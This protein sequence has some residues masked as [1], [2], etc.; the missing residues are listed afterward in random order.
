MGV[1]WN[2]WV[3]SLGMAPKWMNRWPNWP[4]GLDELTVFW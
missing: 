4:P 3:E 1:E 2:E